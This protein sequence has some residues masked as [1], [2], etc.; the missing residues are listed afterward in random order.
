MATRGERVSDGAEKGV[1]CEG[2]QNT[3]GFF[4]EH[5]RHDNLFVKARR[6]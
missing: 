3:M 1:V 6:K 5:D 2:E 4:H